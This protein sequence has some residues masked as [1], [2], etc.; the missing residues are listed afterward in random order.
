[1]PRKVIIA[2]SA[3]VLIY[4]IYLNSLDGEGLAWNLDNSGTDVGEEK[5]SLPVFDNYPQPENG[6]SP[7]NEYF[8]RGIYNNNS[9]NEFIIKNSN[10][11]D[12]VVLLVNAYSG[13]KIR[14]EYIRKGSNFSMT[15]VP[16][17]TYYLQW[18][19]GNNWNPNKA[20]G[21]LIGGFQEDISFSKTENTNDWM[22][23]GTTYYQWTVTLYSVT[24]G[25]VETDNI[26]A[27]EFAN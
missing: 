9:D 10:S 23:V 11:T 16:N 24:G 6:Y 3:I 7:Y 18:S 17:G 14:N 21:S 4:S 1:M 22:S 27:S 26:S 12:A 5:K 13:R 2:I 20:V 25:D 19:S 8:G 15:G